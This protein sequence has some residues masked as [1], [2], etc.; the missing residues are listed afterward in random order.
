M[1]RDTIFDLVYPS[2][3]IAWRKLA[4]GSIKSS[5]PPSTHLHTSFKI[6]N[7]YSWV[8]H[9]PGNVGRSITF[10][11]LA[12]QKIWGLFW[13]QDEQI[14]PYLR[15]IPILMNML[16]HTQVILVLPIWQNQT[17]LDKR[18]KLKASIFKS[19]SLQICKRRSITHQSFT[20]SFP[21]L[22]IFWHGSCS[23]GCARSRP[24][25]DRYIGERFVRTSSK[26]KPISFTKALIIYIKSDTCPLSLFCCWS[27]SFHEILGPVWSRLGPIDVNLVLFKVFKLCGNIIFW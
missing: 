13:I 5:S 11:I 10:L 25:L 27:D 23:R 7:Q 15:S 22:W 24:A 4:C 19:N 16:Y 12:R 9:Q 18:I 20:R 14:Y 8:P 17:C 21:L 6:S 2:Y 1:I 3:L 26:V